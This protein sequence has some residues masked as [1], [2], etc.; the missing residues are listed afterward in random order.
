[1]KFRI[2]LLALL[3]S[4]IY[5]LNGQDLYT[6]STEDLEFI[7][8]TIKSDSRLLVN[9]KNELSY[10]L[11]FSDSDL[12]RKYALE[13]KNIAGSIGY[14]L[15]KSNS[16]VMLGLIAK[17]EMRID[18]AESFLSTALLL[19]KEVGSIKD[20]ASVYNNLGLLFEKSNSIKARQYYK[21][22]IDIIGQEPGHSFNAVVRNNYGNFLVSEQ[23]YD[24][25]H[26]HLEEGLIIRKLNSNKIAL[27]NSY[28]NLAIL[29]FEID[30]TTSF[31]N[32]IDSTLH[33]F[34][35]S[36]NHLGQAKALNLEG[37]FYLKQDFLDKAETRFEKAFALSINNEYDHYRYKKN[38][39]ALA[40]RRR[41]YSKALNIH[42]DCLSF[43][44][45]VNDLKE[46]S[47][48]LINIGTIHYEL[49]QYNEAIVNYEKALQ[50]LKGLN[51]NVLK[52]KAL[53]FLSASYGHIGQFEKSA[54]L[55]LE[56][57]TLRDTYHLQKSKS[58]YSML[59]KKDILI[60]NAEL[61]LNETKLKLK[62]KDAKVQSIRVKF[63]VGLGIIFFLFLLAT[64]FANY[65]RQEKHIAD[66]KINEVLSKSELKTNYARLDMQE[67]ERN[68]I[69]RDLHD[70][71]GSTF[72]A[73]KFCMGS[74]ES[75]LSEIKGENKAHYQKVNDLIDLA[76]DDVRNIAHDLMNSTLA[77]F[78][79][80]AGLE[81]LVNSLNEGNI[82][83]EL[84]IYGLDDTRMSN[85]IELNIYQIIQEL[86]SNALKHS[87]ASKM[88]IQ[89]N[90]FDQRLN[91]TIEDNGIG[92]DREKVK[93]GMGIKNIETRVHELEG[94]FN[95]DSNRGNGTT[96][97][98]DIPLQNKLEA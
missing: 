84:L 55:G 83:L 64:G 96:V 20:I 87:N 45:E 22:G 88:T 77:N 14:K 79:L 23:E 93:M 18:S 82:T 16:F 31:R 72:S 51:N 89:L 34:N 66:L 5:D 53:L 63:V 73:I 9:V 57:Q 33:Y 58:L 4:G 41:E 56:Y 7:Q 8:D 76:S 75:T 37:M 12:A 29:H 98:I 74:V 85:K 71:L 86:T 24:E 62:I 36:N 48:I 92:F 43:F 19:R 11:R 32:H 3:I 40:L 47:G 59:D 81:S 46:V 68:R 49:T 35:K 91:I 26:A 6:L 15:G 27:A 50:T 70:R 2:I 13:A 95:L 39:G 54:N 44:S 67:K 65:Y 1:M 38:L 90:R 94:N 78:G 61:K 10:K 52:A 97:I 21:A 60:Q 17:R 42:K 30:D 28:L 25:A 69:A 80:K